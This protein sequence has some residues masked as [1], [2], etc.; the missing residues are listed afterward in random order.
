VFNLIYNGFA[1]FVNGI[2][3]LIDQIPF[4][5]VGRV[6]YRDLDAGHLD[7]ITLE[8]V[9]KAGQTSAGTGTSGSSAS[10]AV[11]RDITVNVSITTSALVGGD[12]I[13]QFALIIGRELRSAGVLGVA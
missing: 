3:W 7:E 4:V 1:A 13:Q 8:D 9:S 6:A 11:A 5:N 12:G 10:Y 2:L